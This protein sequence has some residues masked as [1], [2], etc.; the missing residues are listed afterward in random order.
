MEETAQVSFEYLLTA[1][2]A[3][4]L[5][6]FSALMVE[7]LRSIAI[8]SQAD[9]LSARSRVIENIISG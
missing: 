5:A 7:T 3:I 2:F 9:M 1:A 4:M 8:Q 6:V